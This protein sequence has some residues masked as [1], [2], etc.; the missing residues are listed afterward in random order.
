MGD[1]AKWNAGFEKF[2]AAKPRGSFAEYY[3]A[4][5]VTKIRAGR[6][7]TS[8]GAQL[9][10]KTPGKEVDFA[11]AG[12]R[13][14]KSLSRNADLKADQRVIDYG[15]GS[16]R[17]GLHFIRFLNPD[18]FMGLD[19]TTDFIDI[20]KELIGRQ[21]LDEKRPRLAAISEGSLSG[22]EAF[23]A[24]LVYST[25]V[26]CHVHPDEL[27]AYFG[28][29]RRLAAKKGATLLFNGMM[30]D[31]PVRYRKTGWAWPLE[32]Y[33]ELLKPLTFVGT[34]SEREVS[35]YRAEVADLTWGMM[36]FRSGGI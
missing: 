5:I 36:K 27:P 28:N 8:L 3:V 21:L 1:E 31:R 20:G 14:F 22:A 18:N 10:S 9:L 32:R 13:T 34:E 29:L 6:E 30:A 2:R 17:V 7:H 11:T 25:A 23:G 26:C 16:L 12:E 15:C 24:D 35:D 4:D 33:I 19:V